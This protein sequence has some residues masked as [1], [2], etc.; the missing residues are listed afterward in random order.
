[1][2]SS[3]QDAHNPMEAKLAADVTETFEEKKAELSR[4]Q[5][6]A[7]DDDDISCDS[8]AAAWSREG[9]RPRYSAWR[10]NAKTTIPGKKANTDMGQLGLPTR[11]VTADDEAEVRHPP[12]YSPGSI[13]IAQ[14]GPVMAGTSS[15]SG[16]VYFR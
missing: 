1:M 16:T 11:N 3:D 10:T 5:S 6:G 7:F 13:A 12:A 4:V 8:S 9:N 2:D 15:E 14:V